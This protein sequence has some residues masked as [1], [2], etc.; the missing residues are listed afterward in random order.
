VKVSREPEFPVSATD[1]AAL[2]LETQTRESFARSRE[3]VAH[4]G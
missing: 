2:D 3:I 4:E 1:T